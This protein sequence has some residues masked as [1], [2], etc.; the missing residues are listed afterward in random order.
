M[1]APTPEVQNKAVAGIQHYAKSLKFMMSTLANLPAGQ[2]G[3]AVGA[4]LELDH[5]IH[6]KAS[7][8]PGTCN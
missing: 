2:E 1:K 6:P 5:I 8:N 7:R 4:L 3:T